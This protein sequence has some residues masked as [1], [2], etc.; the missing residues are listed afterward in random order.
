M[1]DPSW[2]QAAEDFL[3]RFESARAKWKLVNDG[4]EFRSIIMMASA[5]SQ[6]LVVHRRRVP[7]VDSN[8][9]SASPSNLFFFLV[10]KRIHV[11]A[12]AP[13]SSF[14]NTSGGATVWRGRAPPDMKL[15]EPDRKLFEPDPEPLEAEQRNLKIFGWTFFSLSL[16]ITTKSEALSRYFVQLNVWLNPNVS[17]KL[18]IFRKSPQKRQLT[19]SEMI[20][21]K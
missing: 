6:R 2:R 15:F 17:K 20:L 1:E 21:M 5:F 16:K 13:S 3:T 19:K 12:L 14:I 10:W 11:N 8:K 18:P 4:D 7:S 9:T